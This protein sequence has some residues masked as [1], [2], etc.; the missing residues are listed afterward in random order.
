MVCQ[1]DEAFFTGESFV[2]IQKIADQAIPCTEQVAAGCVAW[3]CR[4][5]DCVEEK[6]EKAICFGED[7]GKDLPI[8]GPEHVQ[9]FLAPLKGL[10]KLVEEK[11]VVFLAA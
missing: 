8:A 2:S 4:V 5:Q 3:M 6:M 7:E 1:G 9:D 11:V 10:V